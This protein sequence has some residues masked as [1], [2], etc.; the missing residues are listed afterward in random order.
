PAVS[1]GR[2]HAP[3]VRSVVSGDLSGAALSAP[4]AARNTLHV[5]VMTSFG[6]GFQAILLVAAAFAALSALLTWALV[7]QQE[8]APIERK[9]RPLR[10]D[11]IS[12][13]KECPRSSA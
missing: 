5:L 8:T 7:R 12:L 2:D 6:D 10:S 13:V 4:E 3:L 11:A 1:A 9:S